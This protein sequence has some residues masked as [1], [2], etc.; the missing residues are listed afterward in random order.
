MKYRPEI[1]GLRAL[2]V[3]AVLFHH[4]N[5]PFFSGGFLGVDIFFVISGYLITSV[6]LKELNQN[7]FSVIKFYERRAR[8]LIP[9]LTVVLL[10]TS[11]A[12]LYFLPAE[13]TI[14][15][16]DSLKF[17]NFY[18]SNFFFVN[19]YSY[20]DLKAYQKP[21]LHTWSL[22]VEEQFY[23]FYPILL[24]LIY[25][26]NKK[27]LNLSLVILFLLSLILCQFLTL[28]DQNI[29]FYMLPTRAWELLCGSL[30]FVFQDKWSQ[31]SSKDQLISFCCLLII[32]LS[33]SL[34]SSESNHPGVLTLFPVISAGIL[35]VSLR[36]NSIVKKLLSGTVVT[37]LGRTSYTLYLVHWPMVVFCHEIHFNTLNP[38]NFVSFL[39]VLLIVVHVIHK[40]IENPFRYGFS[41]FKYFGLKFTSISM[42]LLLFVASSGA[43]LG[44][45]FKA[46]LRVKEYLGKSSQIKFLKMRKASNE[47]TVDKSI[48]K[49][50][51]VVKNFEQPLQ[52]K[53]CMEKRVTI[54]L[55]DS[56]GRDLFYSLA[57]ANKDK[58]KLISI[59]KGGCRPVN[60]NSYCNGH[61]DKALGWI[62]SHNKKIEKIIYHQSGHV[63][64]IDDKIDIN[65][66]DET[67]SYLKK[68]NH[69]NLLFLG[70]KYDLEYDRYEIYKAIC[71]NKFDLKLETKID[72]YISLDKLLKQKSLDYGIVYRSLL[73]LMDMKVPQDITDCE[74]FFWSNSRHWSEQ[75][76]LFFSERIKSLID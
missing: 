51:Q 13:S 42:V 49:C 38:I 76:E 34:F 74:E 62:E 39:L 46:F 56:Q 33:I 60:T 9:S 69:P 32:L 2:S 73:E 48:D 1:D 31:K 43:K 24:I 15:Y 21:L 63:F 50:N 45:D 11:L 29:S 5:I 44:S 17:T 4:L 59:A 27:L 35:L 75:G 40:C 28:Y 55:G 72:K 58:V 23:I 65:I 7:T 19:D 3:W 10:M 18:L 47:V 14:K 57:H 36:Q 22:A 66:I 8:R 53:D 64:F 67:F 41:N 16:F 61:P 26:W 68:I 12:V 54:I 20:F 6:I 25:K 70:P 30:V 37:Y 71:L 52:S